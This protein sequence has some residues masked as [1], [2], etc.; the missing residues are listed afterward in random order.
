MC[1]NQRNGEYSM[2]NVIV[3][4]DYKRY[5]KN[6]TV[7]LSTLLDYSYIYLRIIR[8]A[9]TRIQTTQNGIFPQVQT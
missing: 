3:K 1:T 7:P 4:V 9:L 8:E 2:E 5:C 6:S